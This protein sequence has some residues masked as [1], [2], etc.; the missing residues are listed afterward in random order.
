MTAPDPLIVGL[1]GPAGV[2]KDTA[3]DYLVHHQGFVRYAFA[4]PLRDMIEALLV[5]AGLDYAYIYERHLKEQPIPGLDISYRQLAQ[6]LGTEWGRGLTEDLWLRLAALN[7][8]LPLAPVHD[9]I[10]ITDVRFPNE[11]AWVESHQGRVV[12]IFRSSDAVRPHI[13]EQL[14]E[15]IKPWTHIDNTGHLDELHQQLD[16]MVLALKSPRHQPPEPAP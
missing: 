10:V 9:R 3:A 8:G 2:G 15:A 4:D 11:A 6:T 16:E 1:C 7:L 14:V 5:S 12:R 13:S